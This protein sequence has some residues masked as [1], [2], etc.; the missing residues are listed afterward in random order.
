[1][2]GRIFLF[3]FLL[4]H[5]VLPLQAGGGPTWLRVVK[6]S[7]SRPQEARLQRL[8]SLQ[9]QHVAPKEVIQTSRMARLADRNRQAFL[10]SAKTLPF[11]AMA[12]ISAPV[13]Q[14]ARQADPLFALRNDQMAFSWFETIEKD[15][16]FWQE[17]KAGIF[18]NLQMDVFPFPWFNYVDWIPAQARKI[19]VGEEHDQPVIYKAFEAMVLQYKQRYPD[20]PIIV[21]T[22]FV[23]DR[24][25]SWQM[26]GQPVGRLEMRK[27][28]IDRD[29]KFFSHFIK[30]GIQVIGLE[31]LAYIKEHEA[32][33]TP[34]ESQAQSVYGMQQRNAHWRTIIDYVAARNPQAVLFIYTG[35]MHSHYRAPFSLATPSPQNFVM[36]FE[37]GYLGEDMPFGYVMQKEPFTQTMPEYITVL[38]WRKRGAF[39]TRSGFDVCFIFPTEGL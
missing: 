13:A 25:F 23:S 32:L 33:I 2:F 11:R 37:V 14:F 10:R 15:L 8:I 7:A 31:N 6:K 27:R 22:E 17:Q 16:A 3:F 21:L 12:T 30:E 38:S 39:S 4:L 29:F 34:S 1:M 18:E 9:M 28:R 35:S 24:F 19:Y 36:Q 26:P 20:R 5:I